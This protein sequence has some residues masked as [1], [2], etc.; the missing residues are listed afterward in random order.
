MAYQ[1]D[2]I[3][4]DSILSLMGGTIFHFI[5]GIKIM[6]GNVTPYV[7]SYLVQ[8]NPDVSYHNTLHVY[9][10]VFLGQSLFMY[11]GGQLEKKIGPRTTC[12]IGAA[13]ISS[14]T[15]LSSYCKS[16]S[17]LGIVGIGIG[18]S[19][20]SPIVCGFKY[21]KKSKGIVTGVITTGTGAGP[22]LFGLIATTF[23]NKENYPV[24]GST[25]LYDPETSPVVGRV[26]S[27]FR[28][29]GA[30]YAVCGFLGAS[31]L[32]SPPDDSHSMEPTLAGIGKGESAPINA[33]NRSGYGETPTSGDDT[34][35]P[36]TSAFVKGKGHQRYGSRVKFTTTFELTTPQMIRDSLCWLLIATKIFTGV[37][38]FYVA[39]TYK[40]FGQTA[41]SDDHFITV[42]GCLGC[43]SSGVS[44]L[45]WGATADKIGHFKALEVASYASP[46]FMIIYTLTVQSKLCFGL[47]AVVLLFGLWGAN[48]CL[49]PSIASF[50]FGDKH[51]GTNY[52]FIFLVFGLS[53]TFII[54]VSG[55]S[56]VSFFFLNWVFVIVGFIGAALCSQIRYLTTK[57]SDEKALKHH[58]ATSSV[59]SMI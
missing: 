1:E 7:T 3:N 37:S 38:G 27:M 47:S 15:Y 53:C 34:T 2:V 41:I 17:T 4:V 30:I 31:L 44:R 20:S 42:V 16:I 11:L 26:P 18:L 43:L 39:A 8:F 35:I 36:N 5:V 46:V 50:L 28:L 57:V 49:L 56:G 40:S 58:R 23:V 45:V 33:K 54:D 52:G 55:G 14:G 24:D 6:W 51:M 21:F 25:G 29:L 19:Y 10:A 22:F 13:L 59:G 48:Y 9:T 12:F 32:I